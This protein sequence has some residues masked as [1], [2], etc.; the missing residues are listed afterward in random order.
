MKILF[1]QIDAFTDRVFGGNPAAV[2]PLNEWLPDGIMQKIAF[3][4]N[5]AETAFFVKSESGY[6]IRWFMPNDEIDLCG[7]ATLA[8]AYTIFNYL[9]HPSHEITFSSQ[10]GPLKAVMQKEGMI[11]LD[12]PS[13][14]P[15]PIAVPEEILA[16]F[17][18]APLTAA[19][20]R[21]L[22]LLFENEKQ[23]L[24]ADP[25]L[26]L[27]KAL[28]YL[29]VA[30]TARGEE[31]DFVSRVF[32]ANCP[33]PEDPVTGSTHAS[34]VPFWAEKLGKTDFHA[35][36]LSARGGD[37]FCRLQGERVIISGHAVPFMKGEI[38]IDF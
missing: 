27:L 23:I 24:D 22:I 12:F 38:N 3:E 37:L 14:P 18:Q 7:H 32:D 28:P 35:R 2:C 16:A 17:K 1:Y 30:V 15:E 13:R 33:I 4:F 29:G 5:Q 19:A 6:E 11:S 21:D 36:Q 8:S 26:D 9:D 34:L 20:A 31:V 10:S 25:K